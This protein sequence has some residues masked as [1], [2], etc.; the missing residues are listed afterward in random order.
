MRKGKPRGN[1]DPGMSEERKDGIPS[2]DG[3][4]ENLAKFR[5][6]ALQYMFT[7]ECH[8]RYLAGPRL[9]AHL[10]GTARTVVRRKLV[11][12]PQWLA[13]PRGAYVLVDYLEQAIERPS[14]V[15][16]SQHIQK[17]FYALRR[18]R[19]EGMTAWTNRHAEALWEASR[20]L[21]RVQKD[22]D[23][24]YV[25]R[26]ESSSGRSRRDSMDAQPWSTTRNEM[27][28][29]GGPF[30]DN[31]LLQEEEDDEEEVRSSGHRSQWSW[32]QQDWGSDWQ[33]HGWK[34]DEYLPPST[35]ETEVKDFL[36]DYLVGFLL[37]QRSGLDAHERA[38][39]L[40]AIRGK[41][42]VAS[43][44]RAL[45]EQWSDDDLQRRDRIKQASSLVADEEDAQDDDMAMTLQEDVPDQ[46]YEPEAYAAFM[47]E[48]AVIDS[49][50]E[51]IQEKKR[52]LREARWRQTQ[53]RQSRKFYPTKNFSSNRDRPQYRVNPDSKCLKCGGPH[54]T[55]NC[56]VRKQSAQVSEEAAEIAFGA[57]ED[58][59]PWALSQHRED[60][61]NDL[62]QRIAA[63]K[64][65]IDCGATSTLGSV[66][67]LESIMNNNQ[68]LKGSDRVSV[69]TSNCP[70][71]RF[72]N[73]G[74]TSCLSTVNL[75][76]DMGDKTGKME[77]HIHDMPDQPVLVPVKALKKLGAILDFGRS[78]IL[79]RN[80]CDRSVVPLETAANG[81]LLMPLNG[82][83]LEGAQKR[84]QPFRQLKDE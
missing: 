32:R 83:L 68:N 70:T 43:V 84:Q 66:T 5:E 2:Y 56:P 58:P 25:A 79:Y 50:L 78:E 73:N 38:N 47:E 80:V 34:S 57:S 59:E 35:W 64:G 51:A 48:Q 67:A 16:A 60:L 69:D 77:I 22:S 27:Y 9:A 63:G 61:K 20:A 65:V 52:T 28:Q 7:L 55:S 19:G 11:Q 62:K 74:T 12:D 3:T 41:F 71:F 39:I 23:G 72:G 76:V 4:P 49:A 10:T 40:A 26:G 36:P 42:S 17:F 18:K 54:S 15:L 1:P 45:K 30:D 6:E 44:E 13:Q 24:D 33:W 46:S 53:V 21:Q 8:K 31:G 81:H 29:Q 37:L 14:L 82:N 75:G